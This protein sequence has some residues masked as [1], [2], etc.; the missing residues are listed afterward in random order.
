MQLHW[1]I[2]YRLSK[3]PLV[4]FII[5]PPIIFIIVNRFAFDSPRQ[6]RREKLGVHLTSLSI[7]ASLAL[8]AWATDW[9]SVALA[10][11]PT[12]FAASVV[13]VWLFSVQH[14]FEGAQWRHEQSW[15]FIEASLTGCSL[16][17]LPSVLEWFSGNIG[18]H[19][20]HPLA[21]G[22]PNYRL[23]SCHRA[24]PQFRNVKIIGLWGAIREIWRHDLWDEE[25]Q[26]MIPFR[27]VLRSG[28]PPS[29]SA[30]SR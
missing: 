1:K 6:W 10:T 9:H 17:K 5:M 13:G 24:H 8:E 22:V 30:S 4:S 25:L 27:Q 7:L 21:P 23:K 28:P 12:V 20:I 19:H 2:L 18:Y 16:L 15:D 29:R 3:S 14:K 11:L 26:Q